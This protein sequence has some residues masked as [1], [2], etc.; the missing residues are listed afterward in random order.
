M[1]EPENF[2][3][4]WSRRKTEAE[5]EAAEAPDTPAA[6]DAQP[7]AADAAKP[8]VAQASARSE[9]A[10]SPAA[11]KP[12]FDLASL[13]SLDSITA[14]TDI[15]GFL[16][17]RVPQELSRAALRRAWL[18]DPAIR[19]FV[20]LQ[21]ND[22]DF[23]NPAAVPGFGE[24]PPGYDIKKMIA[25]IF[26]EAEPATEQAAIPQTTQQ[27][28]GEPQALAPAPE[29]Q[30]AETAVATAGDPETGPDA[31]P[32]RVSALPDAPAE[33]LQTDFVQRETNIATQQ[34]ALESSPAESK[35]R[36]HHGGALPRS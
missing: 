6:V 26:G 10:S 25:Q 4:R 5:R 8:D 29:S 36:R 21:E 22:W 17:P 9:T 19:D 15:R 7:G 3:T 27:S 33:P 2:L 18:A 12:E 11:A 1:T 31:Q 20:G 13:P 32:V 23:T 24:M 34:S 14:M 30:P 16:S 28:A 35:R